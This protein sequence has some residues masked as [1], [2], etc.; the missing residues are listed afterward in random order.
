[1]KEMNGKELRCTVRT[2]TTYGKKVLRCVEILKDRTG[3]PLT[4]LIQEALIF[5]EQSTREQEV[6][7]EIVLKQDLKA[8]GVILNKEKEGEIKTSG[9]LLRLSMDKENGYL[10]PF[11]NVSALADAIEQM[12]NKDS[13][14]KYMSKKAIKTA[15]LYSEENIIPL[16]QDFFSKFGYIN[17]THN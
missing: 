10:V 1:M 11:K 5:F 15:Q 7:A 8:E 6:E 2:D 16:W 12:I 9:D 14:R 17:E 3:L 4:S 13:N